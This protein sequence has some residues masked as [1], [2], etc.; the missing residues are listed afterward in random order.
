MLFVHCTLES[1]LRLSAIKV[2]L[3]LVELELALK[4]TGGLLLRPDK[5]TT[6]MGAGEKFRLN[7]EKTSEKQFAFNGSV[8][9]NDFPDE[10]HSPTSFKIAII[11]FT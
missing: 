11:L 4:T 7:A 9:W 5:G 8:M 6:H 3:E 2:E 10:L 1:A